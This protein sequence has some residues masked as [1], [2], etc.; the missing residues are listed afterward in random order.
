M[1]Y[2]ATYSGCPNGGI[3]GAK[4]IKGY[5]KE[6]MKCGQLR[7]WLKR[8]PM[9]VAVDATG[10]SSYVSGIYSGCSTTE[11]FYVNHAVLLVGVDSNKNWRIKNSWGTDWG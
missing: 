7:S 2:T 4:Q 5:I 10:W 8:G 1:S 3:S 11:S 6:S 9:S